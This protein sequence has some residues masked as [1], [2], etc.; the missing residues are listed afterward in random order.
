MLDDSEVALWIAVT[1]YA[2]RPS[3]GR[4]RKL[5]RAARAFGIEP[6]LR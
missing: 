1:R 2:E 4:E 3:K 6:D 5:K